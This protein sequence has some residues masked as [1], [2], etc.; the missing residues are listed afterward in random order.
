MENTNKTSS[1]NPKA[2]NAL[3]AINQAMR[4]SKPQSKG[5]SQEEKQAR[6]AERQDKLVDYL[7]RGEFLTTTRGGENK[8]EEVFQ[9]MNPAQTVEHVI[10]AIRAGLSAEELEERTQGAFRNRAGQ[11]NGWDVARDAIIERV[12]ADKRKVDVNE[13]LAAFKLEPVEEEKEESETVA[14]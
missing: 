6:K 7:V 2:A 10:R 14:A 9:K 8:D 13:V 3:K 1:R 5:V 11:E 12:N 4:G